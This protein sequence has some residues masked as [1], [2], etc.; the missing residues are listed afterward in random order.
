MLGTLMQDVRYAFRMMWKSPVFTV[1]TVFALALGIGANT[2]IFSAINAV[3]LRPLPYGRPEQLVLMW[4]KNPRL[5]DLDRMW[6]S[7]PDYLDWKS[8]NQ[9]FEQIGVY[10]TTGAN[11]TGGTEPERVQVAEVSAEFFPVLGIQPMVGRTFLPEEDRAGAA[12]S[13]VISH[14]L[15]QRRFGSD[16]NIMGKPLVLDGDSFTV[17]GIMPRS[18]NFPERPSQPVEAWAPVG[19]NA[20]QPGF[21]R[22]GNHPGLTA[23]ARLKPGVTFEQARA[24]MEAVSRALGAQYPDTNAE[25]T[26]TM[27]TLKE[28]LTG[29]IR[30][31]LLVL[32]AGVAFVLLIACTNVANLLLARAAARQKEMAIRTALGASRLRVVRQLL[33]ESILLAL[34]GGALGLVLALWGVDL[35]LAVSPGDIPRLGDAG[36]DSHV[37]IFSLAISLLTGI[38]FGLAP[39]LATSKLDLTDAL[40]EGSRTSSGGF[41]RNRM[42]S[43]L[44]VSELALALVLLVGAGLMIKSFLRLQR[45]DPGFQPQHVLTA[46]IPL[47]TTKYSEPSQQV[48]FFQQVTERVRALPGVRVAGLGSNPPLSGGS[49]QSGAGIEG[50]VMKDFLVDIAIIS[51]DYMRALGIPL[52]QGRTFTEQDKEETTPVVLIDE[53]LAARYWPGEDPVGKR[54]GFDRDEK[55][56]PIWREI[57]GVVG[58][59]KQYGL[60][61]EARVQI[62]VPYLQ[63]PTPSMTLVVR[64]DGDAVSLASAVRREILAVDKDQPVAYLRTMDDFLSESVAQPRFNTLLLGIFASVALLLAGIGIYG[65]IAYSVMQR[66]HEIGIR[67]ALGAQRRDILKLVVGQGMTLALVGII[68]GLTAAFALTRVMSSLLFGVS[69]T[70]PLTFAGVSL[71]LALVALIAIYIPA[72]R[73][74]RVDPMVALRYE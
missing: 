58:H 29:D 33:T 25:N 22:R 17:I 13:I 23:I 54:M 8:Q 19:L 56:Q 6:V 51:P 42:R 9:V 49:W 36:I 18:F 26:V 70:D 16:P 64:A 45:V 71:L 50:R 66:T 2:A 20:S 38:I 48:A 1:V 40:K 30:P 67:M 60:D 24:N 14:G 3:L 47:P 12:P 68:L 35:L 4:E 28:E 65:V 27:T 44:V 73:A 74:M 11:L 46:R 31:A 7:Y 62:Y 57:V 32:L 10:R 63:V 37:L 43:L 72:R 59:V 52:E 53:E 34:L 5:V 61:A 69:A 39:A 41:Q 15:W 21:I 55:G